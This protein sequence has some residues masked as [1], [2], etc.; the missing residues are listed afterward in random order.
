MSDTPSP[1]SISEL[2]NQRM[3]ILLSAATLILIGL[4]SIFSATQALDAGSYHFLERQ[5]IWLAL[6][7]VC[8]GVASMVDLEKLRPLIP[9]LALGAMALL[10]AVLIPGVGKLVNGSR[11][12]IDLGPLGFQPSEFAKV[13]FVL[14]MAAYL[15]AQQRNMK[16]IGLGFLVPMMMVGLFCGL[17]ILEPDFGTCFLYGVV[18]MGMLYLAGG[19]MT[20]IVPTIIAGFSGFLFLIFQDPVRLRR[21]L[22]FLDVE[23]NRQDGAYQVYQGWLAFSDGGLLGVGAGDGRYQNS[24]LPEA[25]TDFIFSIVGEEF[26]LIVTCLVAGLFLI[27]FCSVV[28]SMRKAPDLYQSLLV[29]GSVFMI[30]LQAI[31]NMG[32]VTGL[33]PTKGMSLPF[34][35]YGGSNLVVMCTFIGILVNCLKRWET[36]PIQHMR[37][38]LV[39]IE[40]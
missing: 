39:E 29:L 35:S 19:R 5:L 4:I 10:V 3:L 30:S 26:G 36:L 23:G 27:M 15:G 34:I 12:W 25:H 21:L 13:P 8:G 6:A 7:L 16:T 32:V 40:E 22:S 9:W 24:F 14:L 20:Y 38:D 11:R 1:K 31:I 18:G 28:F 17:I 33:L 37:R 2:L